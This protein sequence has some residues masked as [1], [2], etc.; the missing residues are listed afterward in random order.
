MDPNIFGKFSDNLRKILVLAER[1][2]KDSAKPLDTEDMLLALVLTKGTL[3]SDI[4]NSLEILPEKVSIIAKLVSNQSEKQD[5]PAISVDA[6]NVMQGAVR[7]A[8]GYN[9]MVV[10][11]EHLLLALLSD[12]KL[13]SYSIIER[14]GI[15]P[16]RIAEQIT[17]IFNEI[18]KASGSLNNDQSMGFD[19]PNIGDMPGDEFAGDMNDPSGKTKTAEIEKTFLE[20]Y[21]TNLTLQAKGNQLDPLI[22]RG[23]EIE[24]V[25]QILSR[26]TKNNPL[27]VGES[28]V[29]KTAIVEGLARKIVDGSVPQT[30]I[31]KTI[32]SLDLG[33]LL[34]G[35]MYRGQFESRVKKLLAEIKKIGKIILFIDEIHTTV[36]TGSAEGSLDTANMLKPILT[37]SE[38]Q[39]IGAT[40]FDE[41]KKHIEKD[42]AYERRFQIVQV[43]EP[44]V[45]DT[46]KI[47]RGLKQKYEQHHGVKF[48]PDSLIAATELSERYITDRFL[49]DKAIDLIDEAAAATNIVTPES[50]KLAKLQSKLA[51]VQSKKEEAVMTENYES[52]THFR[53]EEILLSDKI[54]ELEK[55]SASQ[56]K[57]TIDASDIAKIVS[58]WTGIQVENLSLDERKRY[59][60]LEERLKKFV[61]GQDEAVSIISKSI[62]RNRAGIS[63]PDR[64]IGSYLFLG[65]TGVGKTHLS[66]TLAKQLF[67]SED[68][69]I[70]IDM[71]EFME[72]H[73][74]SRLVGAPAGYI[75]YDDGGKLTEA[76]RRKPYSIVLFDEI[77]KAHPEV[78]NILLQIL[79]DGYL[80]DA[81]GRQVNFRNT[82][83][84]MTSNLGTSE[85]KR[86]EEIGFHSNTS[87][88]SQHEAM[89]NMVMET[90]KKE[91]KPEF[92]NR[93]DSIIVFHQ[94]DKSSITKIVELNLGELAKRMKK[95]GILLTIGSDIKKIISETG[96]SD[97]FGARPI[98][99]V[100][101]DRLEDPISEAIISGKFVSG[102]KIKAYLVNQKVVL[103]K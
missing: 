49:P 8:A 72:K 33:S 17:S 65:P 11:A 75:G 18:S 44:S 13:N 43:P 93:L 50:T 87:S 23:P 68:N 1:I 22:G 39:V 45:N 62:R 64:P 48:T 73:N 47:L 67:G 21:T 95:Q 35:T 54:S 15:K 34:A 102:D 41:Y 66:K 20:Q 101:T 24:R 32:L 37:K 55:T 61:I 6:K 79:E 98:R 25:A 74:V 19:I 2:A 71:S 97:E 88:E 26:R 29:G 92:V 81:K 4:L 56:K 58:R 52:A 103:K 63:D 30:L 3:A 28:G 84:I 46:I 86:A 59:L 16:E 60:N 69:L 70:K 94:L 31:G 51:D 36:G 12:S 83:I 5:T 91:L 77:E 53:E 90:I 27:L 9:H 10:D 38:F 40:T 80:T 89:K 99:R 78:F 96:Y 14:I 76:V 7:I 57:Q 82:V 100:I 85:L 42:P